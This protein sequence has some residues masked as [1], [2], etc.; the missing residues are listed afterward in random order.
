MAALPLLTPCAATSL[1]PVL[2]KVTVN[3]AGIHFAYSVTSLT[4]GSPKSYAWVY[5]AS[6][7]Q[8]LKRYSA[9]VGSCGFWAHSSSI[10]VCAGTSLPSTLLK[11]TVYVGFSTMTLHPMAIC[12]IFALTMVVPLI[13]PVTFPVWSTDA[14]SG[15]KELQ[16]AFWEFPSSTS[17]SVSRTFMISSSP[18][19]MDGSSTFTVQT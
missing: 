16:T 6:V 17:F 2:S 5:S 15:S 3:A 10:T 18:C 13:F 11:D 1:P 9:F 14:M 8:P 4:T 19:L 12:P 7:N